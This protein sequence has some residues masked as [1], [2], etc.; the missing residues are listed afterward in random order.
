MKTPF[1]E[2]HVSKFNIIFMI[3][4]LNFTFIKP[5]V[6][7]I[8]L[9]EKY[10]GKGTQ[11]KSLLKKCPLVFWDLSRLIIVEEVVISGSFC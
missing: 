5:K 1:Y 4:L 7:E 2:F 8:G 9:A 10:W 6:P 3:I 11:P